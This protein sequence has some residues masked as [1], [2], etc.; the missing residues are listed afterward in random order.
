MEISNDDPVAGT[1]SKYTYIQESLA[2]NISDRINICLTLGNTVT[3]VE[4]RNFFREA[5]L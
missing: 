3:F 2:T 5:R 1:Q 4:N